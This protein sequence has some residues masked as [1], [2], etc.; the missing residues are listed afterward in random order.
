MLSAEQLENVQ[1]DIPLDNT[2]ADIWEKPGPAAEPEVSEIQPETEAVPQPE[3]AQAEPEE[4]K[5]AYSE[6]EETETAPAAT[7]E[8]ETAPA[9]TEETEPARAEPEE[10]DVK[11]FRKS[12]HE[13][14]AEQD[15]PEEEPDE[16]EKEVTTSSHVVLKIIAVLLVLCALFEGATLLLANIAPD[17]DITHS[18]LGIEES[19]VGS[20]SSFFSGIFGSK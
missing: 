10:D 2:W 11:I 17:A 4:I 3:A 20:I 15:G 9:A 18:L 14:A 7:E 19:V 5:T 16:D 8:A 12:R 1:T 6:P 13:E